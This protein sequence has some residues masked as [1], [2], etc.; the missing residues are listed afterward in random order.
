MPDLVAT[1]NGEVADDDAALAAIFPTP[2]G[3][4]AVW[5]IEALLS[6]F[7]SVPWATALLGGDQYRSVL[8]KI[9]ERRNFSLPDG[10]KGRLRVELTGQYAAAGL[11]VGRR[12]ELPVR[13]MQSFRALI[14]LVLKHST[15][16]RNATHVRD[17]ANA[18]RAAAN[19]RGGQPNP[20]NDVLPNLAAANCLQQAIE[21]LAPLDSSTHQTLKNTWVTWLRPSLEA[22]E[23][24]PGSTP[25]SRTV[26]K[27][28]RTSDPAWR[29]YVASSG[30]GI[31]RCIRTHRT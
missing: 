19:L 31:A 20:L 7:D 2:A 21:S 24:D 25:K 28:L 1:P 3:I 11:M 27:E 10:Q 4:E 22:L 5:L 15:T 8:E 26:V 29:P 16:S 17:L 14:W 18:V 12:G 23:K 6:V 9:L 13:S 30:C